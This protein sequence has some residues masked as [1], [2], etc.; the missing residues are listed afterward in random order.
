MPNMRTFPNLGLAAATLGLVLAG[1][2]QPGG[3]ALAAQPAAGTLRQVTVTLRGKAI[4]LSEAIRQISLQTGNRVV[5][6]RRERAN[7]PTLALDLSD[8]SFWEAIDV[9]ARAAGL[10]VS[11]YEEDDLVA[12]RDGP[13]PAGPIRYA[14][15]CRIALNRLTE[16]RDLGSGG[17]YL[18]ARLEVAW[19]PRFHALFLQI[20]PDSIQARD[21]R[22]AMLRWIGPASGREAVAGRRATEVELRFQAPARAA[23]RLA[24]LR[25]GLTLIGPAQSVTFTFDRLEGEGEREMTREQV[26]VRLLEFRGDEDRWKAALRLTYPPGAPELESFEGWLVSG[27]ASL[28]AGTSGRR[29]LPK[30]Y[31]TTDRDGH[32]AT[33]KY[34]FDAPSQGRPADWKLVYRAPGILVRV[35]VQFEFKDVPLP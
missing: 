4:L 26:T 27:R 24:L 29:L 21:D 10:R 33:L 13:P 15:P 6:R 25:I 35:P 11:A 9:I 32:S 23:A 28:E 34:Y 22:G 2:V 1:H 7:D 8:G 17:H 20:K 12:L 30:G 5:D 16:V 19:Q 3:S 18:L 14:G 31:E